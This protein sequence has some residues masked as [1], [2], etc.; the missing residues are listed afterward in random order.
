ML[1]VP[2][3]LS[4]APVTFTDKLYLFATR[5][6]S[7]RLRTCDASVSCAELSAKRNRWVLRCTCPRHKRKVCYPRQ[8]HSGFLSMCFV[9]SDFHFRIGWLQNQEVTYRPNICASALHATS[10]VR[11]N[12]SQGIWL[13]SRRPRKDDY[14]YQAVLRFPE[15]SS[16]QQVSVCPGHEV[17]HIVCFLRQVIGIAYQLFV[18]TDIRHRI[19]IPFPAH[20]AKMKCESSGQ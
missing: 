8:S 10:S 11:Y 4:A 16:T 15:F 7:S 13:R 12:C 1:H 5:A 6:S 20:F 17:W 3:I 19:D 18:A 2:V 9:E 14:M